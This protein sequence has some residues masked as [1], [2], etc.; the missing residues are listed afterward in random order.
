MNS[1]SIK[2]ASLTLS[3][4]LTAILFI[5]IFTMA[6]RLP[7]DTDTWWH[8]RSGQYILENRAVPTTDPFS[9]SMA[10]Q[11]WI[12]HGWLAQ[13]FW[14]G[15]FALGG[16]PGLS[17]GLAAL[18]T[19]TFW[20]VWQVTPGNLYI[21]AFTMVLGA[22]TSAVI[23]VARPQMVSFLLAGLALVLLEKYKRTGS[24]WIYA[25]PLIVLLWVNIHGGYAIA[26]MLLGVYLVGEAFNRL[27]GHRDDPVLTWRQ[28]RLLLLLGGVGFALAVVNPHGWQMWFY[29]FR[30]VGIGALR[31]FIQEWRSPDF[32]LS[33][34][35]AFLAMLLASLAALGR[36]GRR[37]DWTD[38]AVLGLWSFWSLF[39]AR[40]IGL[41]GLLTIPALARYADAAW[42]QYLPGERKRVSRELEGTQG[43]GKASSVPTGSFSSPR[44]NWFLLGLVVVAALLKIGAALNPQEVLKAEQESLP[45]KAVE[46]IQQNKPAGPLFNSYNWGGYLIY[47]LWPAYPVYIDGRTDLYD[48]AFIRRYLNVVAGGEGWQHTLDQD[49]VN[50]VLIESDSTLAKFLKS[51]PAWS[52]RYQDAIATVF[53]RNTQ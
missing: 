23:W 11:P 45:A 25:F 46:F 35:W 36:A 42:G 7:A 33:L 16:W 31:D 19:L 13:I 48:D 32:H 14:Y 28:M 27:T 8:L 22:I 39:A 10:G 51:D 5:A 49:G 2:P 52:I 53:V 34:T 3:R 38:L 30:T 29:P 43:T 4:L 21:R 50:V 20:L 6:V 44:L 17:L 12:D 37:A 24:R 1:L 9:H 40:N 47:K 41:F 18:V 15:L 26:F